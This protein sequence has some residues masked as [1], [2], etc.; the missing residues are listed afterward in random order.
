VLFQVGIVILGFGVVGLL[1]GYAAGMLV[2][3]LCGIYFI[4]VDVARPSR[5]HFQSLYS[6]AKYSWLQSFQ[7]RTFSYM[8]VLVLGFFVS[9]DFIGI[10][11]IS[12]QIASFLVIF[13]SSISQTLFPKISEISEG[14]N[15]QYIV[16]LFTDSLSYSGIFIIPG[17]IGGVILGDDILRIYGTEFSA[18][19]MVLS[20]LLFSRLIYVY[21]SQIVSTINAINRPK[22]GF[23]INLVFVVSN[24]GLNVILVW[25]IGWIG[26]AIAT[27]ISAAISLALGLHYITDIIPV[28]WPIKEISL[29]WLAALVMAVFILVLSR[30]QSISGYSISPTVDVVVLVVLGAAV[31]FNCVYLLSPDLRSTV[32]ANI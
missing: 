2:A 17:F 13:A 30:L 1:A 29:Q 16:S 15:E 22:I 21:Q 25:Q 31:Y 28:Q 4:S 26:A 24:I 18:G 8:D 20:I 6:Y 12:W 27:T 5:R 10:Y 3:F 19:E 32:K 11:Q 7:G 9:S 23:K 14:E